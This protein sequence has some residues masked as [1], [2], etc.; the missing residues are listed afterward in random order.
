MFKVY[1]LH[2]HSLNDM[3]DPVIGVGKIVVNKLDK[4]FFL[5][6]AKILIGIVRIMM[7]Q[8]FGVSKSYVKKWHYFL[9]LH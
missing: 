4:N 7:E 9:G 3:L 5:H 1:N 6:R 8:S 2:V